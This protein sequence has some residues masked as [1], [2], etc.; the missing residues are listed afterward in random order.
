MRHF[1]SLRIVPWEPEFEKAKDPSEVAELINWW[2]EDYPD[3][4]LDTVR[5]IERE[6]DGQGSR[7]EFILPTTLQFIHRR[8]FKDLPHAGRWREVNVTVGWGATS[9]RPADY[10]MV[11]KYMNELFMHYAERFRNPKTFDSDLIDWY[12]DMETI[13]PFQDGNGRVGGVVI[14]RLGRQYGQHMLM[15]LQ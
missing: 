4:V 9:Y 12:H 1:E 5:E 13:H 3:R 14:A 15:P 8:I 2:H 10:T 11:P 7:A 6:S